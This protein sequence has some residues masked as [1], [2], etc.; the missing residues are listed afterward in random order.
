MNAADAIAALG[1]QLHVENSKNLEQWHDDPEP[2]D[3]PVAHSQL[4]ND[5]AGLWPD[6]RKATHLLALPRR[7]QSNEPTRG[8][9]E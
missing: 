3:E 8:R 9:Y 2:R 6:A 1:E 4:K 5:A 7:R